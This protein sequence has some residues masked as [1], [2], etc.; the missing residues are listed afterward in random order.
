MGYK[1]IDLLLII[2]IDGTLVGNVLHQLLEWKVLKTFN[3]YKKQ[4]YLDNLKEDLRGGLMR[5]H[6]IDTIQSLQRDF[7]S[8]EM[9]IYTGSSRDW[10]HVLI[11]GIEKTYDIRFNRPLFTQL[12]TQGPN[13]KSIA[14]I[15][16]KIK[17]SLKSENFNKYQIFMIDNNYVLNVHE[18][19]R[20][21]IKCPTYN[22]IQIIDVLRTIPEQYVKRYY[23]DLIIVLSNYKR[24]P[25]IEYT[26]YDH[27]IITYRTNLQN[28]QRNNNKHNN[29][30]RFWNSV[31]HIILGKLK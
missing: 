3:K 7:K 15:L 11:E 31:P 16:P 5:P 18:A 19:P 29:T 14:H 21:L 17:K 9:F 2:D 8:V 10:A 13:Q 23:K 22:Q 6:F 4:I 27:F 20:F 24:I 25:K 12:H 26:S 28:S 30:D 1:H